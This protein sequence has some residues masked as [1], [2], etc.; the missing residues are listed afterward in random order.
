MSRLDEVKAR[1]EKFNNPDQY[2][3]G[4][5]AKD[6]AWAIERIEA[7]EA[8]LRKIA[9]E[10]GPDFDADDMAHQAAGLLAEQVEK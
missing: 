10:G 5:F 9:E 1:L 6:M 3:Y 8:G 4:D 2:V 7:L